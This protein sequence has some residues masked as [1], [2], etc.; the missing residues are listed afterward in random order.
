MTGQKD[1]RNSQ[2]V[3]ESTLTRKMYAYILLHLGIRSW[4]FIL[5]VAVL[6]YLVWMS[7]RSGN[8]S[9]LAIYASLMVVIY[10][11]AVLVSVMSRK[12]RR[13]YIPVK[14]T[15]NESGV[16][17]ETAASRQTLKWNAFVRW[18]RVG[19]YYLI[20][21][22]KRSFFVIPKAKIPEG[23]ITAF[24]NL[25]SRGIIKRQSRLR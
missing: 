24:E 10:V 22:T 21:T 17:K 9:L 16:V 6:A 20:Y 3:I 13:A 2:I 8:Y 18:R 11:G 5:L 4:V 1:R 23:K 15:F 7:I 12:T 25:L 19:A 14:Y